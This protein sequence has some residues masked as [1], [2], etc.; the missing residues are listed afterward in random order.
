MLISH[1]VPG[2]TGEMVTLVRF[3]L[4]QV[5]CA[6]HLSSGVA[7]SH[8]KTSQWASVGKSGEMFCLEVCGV[9]L[10]GWESGLL[11]FPRFSSCSSI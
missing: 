8:V 1:E 3:V 7:S 4:H 10:G 11:H 6:K 5:T 9:I 2:G